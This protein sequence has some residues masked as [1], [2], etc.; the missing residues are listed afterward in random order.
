MQVRIYKEEEHELKVGMFFSDEPGV[1][2]E[3]MFGVRLEIILYSIPNKP[4]VRIELVSPSNNKEYSKA[5]FN[6]FNGP[7]HPPPP[8]SWKSNININGKKL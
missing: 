6:W 4:E 8:I 2:I 7:R 1:Y 3:D 5:A